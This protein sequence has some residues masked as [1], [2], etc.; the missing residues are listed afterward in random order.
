LGS[1]RRDHYG[2][3]P[4]TVIAISDR[5]HFTF[6]HGDTAAEALEIAFFA[7]LAAL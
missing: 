7:R 6:A 4:P 3:A 5:F 1:F 2:Q